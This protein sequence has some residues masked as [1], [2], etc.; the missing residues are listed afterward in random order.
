[1]SRRRAPAKSVPTGPPRHGLTWA[2]LA[3]LFAFGIF[4]AVRLR[5]VCDDAFLSFRYADNLV[6][7]AGLVYNPGEFV[8]GYTNLLWTLLLALFRWIGVEPIPVSQVLGVLA[9]AGAAGILAWWAWRGREERGG[10]FLPVAAAA[11][12]FSTTS[13]NGRPVGSRR[14]SSPTSPC[15]PCC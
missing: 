4:R 6:E 2:V 15:T 8:E 5:W 7:G 13:S 9:Y 14:R 1:M 11:V 12:R 10:E 3:A